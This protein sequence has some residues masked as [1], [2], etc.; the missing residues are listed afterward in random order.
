M[1]KG[2]VKSS[3]GL[4]TVRR[5]LMHHKKKACEVMTTAYLTVTPDTTVETAIARLRA[6]AQNL[7]MMHYIY[8]VNTENVLQGVVSIRGLLRAQ[9]NQLLTEIWAQRL[10][11]VKPETNQKEIVE[12]F[13]KY[14]LQ[15]LPV[16]DEENHLKGV[17]HFQ[18]VLDKLV[19]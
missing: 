13:A 9:P 16:L 18:S 10:I 19:P 2:L 11:S 7:E 15:A 12:V 17:I 5:S 8:I 1:A 4:R 3:M 6:E 14:R